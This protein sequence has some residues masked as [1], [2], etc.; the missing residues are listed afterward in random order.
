[1]VVGVTSCMAV[2]GVVASQS[3]FAAQNAAPLLVAQADLAQMPRANALPGYSI[4]GVVTS[5]DGRGVAGYTVE[6]FT[7]DGNFIADTVTDVSGNYTLTS[8]QAGP[9]KV[10]M[11]GPTGGTAPWAM[12]WVGGTSVMTKARV[13]VV[14]AKGLKADVK[15]SPA[16]TLTGRVTGVPV[17]SEVRS[18]G[19]T[20][21]DCLTAPVA[22][23]GKFT[24]RGLAP[25]QNSIVV[26]T[27]GS[28]ELAFPKNP[29]RAEVP[30]RA[31]QT[32][33]V[34]LDGRTQAAPIVTIAGKPVGIGAAQ[35]PRLDR[36]GP[37]VTSATITSEQGK[38]YVQVNAS[39]GQG[40]SGLAKVQV[41]VGQRE[42]P[43]TRYTRE[44]LAA[45]GTEEVAVRVIDKA[46]NSSAWAVAK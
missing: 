33:N 37:A 8:L 10:R 41:K 7:P 31:G 19:A 17:G 14:G 12:A 25:G 44:P 36:S 46:G 1:M 24:I 21:L 32:T 28:G 11:S 30:L 3:G 45:P 5:P 23:D 18:C 26:R 2:I 43:A 40:G 6:A 13:L 4:S 38:R 9:Y 34:S 16:A 42:L 20:F 39:D 27:G 29:P 15:L 35:T 22:P